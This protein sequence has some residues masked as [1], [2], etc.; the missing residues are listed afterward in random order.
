M[1]DVKALS[2]PFAPE[3]ISW[4]VGATSQAK[5]KGLAL[6]YIDARDVMQR[7]DDVCGVDGWKCWYSHAGQ[8]TVCDLSIRFGDEWITKA[9][10]AGDT[11]TEAE[12]GALSDAFKR[13]AVLFGIG[14]YLYD[15]PSIWV[16][17]VQQGR[18]YIIAD[19]EYARLEDALKKLSA[20]QTFA[21]DP[22]PKEDAPKNHGEARGSVGITELKAQVGKFLDDLR[23]WNDPL[24][25]EGFIEDN[26]ELLDRCKEDL[27]Q[28]YFGKS[29]SD[30]KGVID[31]IKEKRAALERKAA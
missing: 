6:A 2:A 5:D 4:R 25:F 31:R 9:N 11:D 12:K 7:L 20:G 26:V 8:K 30:V 21:A 27:P 16:K 10:G 15:V 1:I 17:I 28:W 18:S 3:R 24:S 22:R 14:R 29:G 13:A 19:T 23:D